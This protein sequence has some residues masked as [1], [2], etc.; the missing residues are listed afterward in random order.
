MKAIG[1]ILFGLIAVSCKESP[2][3]SFP[4]QI[5]VGQI[6]AYVF[7]NNRGLE[8]KEIVLV[9]TADTLF[10][11]VNGLAKFSLPAG[12]YTVR[13]FGINRAGPCCASID[14]EADVR[15]GVTTKVNIWDCLLCL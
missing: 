7:W 12:H 11:D 8:G 9:E 5:P 6:V 4:P 2:S 1:L 15:V 3:Q 14:F 13:A 10:T